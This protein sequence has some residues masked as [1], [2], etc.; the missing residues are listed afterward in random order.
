MSSDILEE[1]AAEHADVRR[2]FSAYTGLP[3]HD[4]ERK[5]LVEQ[6]TESLIRQAGQ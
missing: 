2:M 3:F 5:H 1:L 4:P 6:A